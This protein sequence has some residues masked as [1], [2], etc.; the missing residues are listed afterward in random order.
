MVDLLWQDVRFAW[1]GWLRRPGFAVVAVLTLGLGIGANTAM[2]R[3]AGAG[4]FRPPAPA[5]PGRVG[6]QRGGVPGPGGRLGST[7]SSESG[8]EARSRRP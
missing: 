6:G 5:G 7:A 3:V 2:F 4:L 1:R 8:C